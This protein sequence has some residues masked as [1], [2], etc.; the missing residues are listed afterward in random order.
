MDYPVKIVHAPCPIRH[1]SC[2]MLA[3]L[4]DWYN[5]VEEKE[6]IQ[7]LHMYIAT[8]QSHWVIYTLAHSWY[9]VLPI[10]PVVYM[11]I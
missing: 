2:S 3:T 1:N 9:I 11:C 7:I 5:S 6:F 8:G 4:N 10:D